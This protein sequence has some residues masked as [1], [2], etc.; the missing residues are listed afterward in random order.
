MSGEEGRKARFKMVAAS[1]RAVISS[2]RLTERFGAGGAHVR[3]R[4]HAGVV[5]LYGR[6]FILDGVAS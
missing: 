5:H 2:R 6:S 4:L 1:V 3:Q